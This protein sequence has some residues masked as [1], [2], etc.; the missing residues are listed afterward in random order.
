MIEL[1]LSEIYGKSLYRYFRA[2]A[3]RLNQV[4]SV[5]FFI[6]FV[7]TTPDIK[8]RRMLCDVDMI[9]VSRKREVIILV[10]E[11][12]LWRRFPD[13]EFSDITT[14]F[15]TGLSPRTN[16]FFIYKYFDLILILFHF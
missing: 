6:Y 9:K 16:I 3:C 13:S 10:F 7:N 1:P 8:I 11:M 15:T 12:L 4:S 5:K 2:S 14:S